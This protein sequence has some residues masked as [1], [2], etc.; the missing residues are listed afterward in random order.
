M[1]L[2]DIYDDLPSDNELLW[3]YVGMQDYLETHFK[4]ITVDPPESCSGSMS[5]R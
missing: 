3:E 5:P 1:R 4:V 2:V